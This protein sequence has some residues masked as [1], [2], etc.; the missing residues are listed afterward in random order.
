M[1]SFSQMGGSVI[2][3]SLSGTYYP[4]SNLGLTFVAR[5]FAISM[6]LHAALGLAKEFV[7]PRFT[8][9]SVH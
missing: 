7:L 9:K 3:A 6:G 5:N 1:T 4:G 8:S 2:A